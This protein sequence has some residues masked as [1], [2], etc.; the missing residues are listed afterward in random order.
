MA[1]AKTSLIVFPCMFHIKILGLNHIDLIPEV[2]AILAAHCENFNPVTDITTKTST[3]S[4]YL[5]L[6]ATI[7]A[8]SQIQLDT[9]YTTLN[10]HHL[11]K[12]TL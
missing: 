12:I 4:N 5:A 10:Q 3:A 2:T 6:T 8:Q 9:I 11:V 1:T 7:L